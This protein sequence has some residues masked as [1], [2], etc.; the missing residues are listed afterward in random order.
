MEN[1]QEP[2]KIDIKYVDDVN[3]FREAAISYEQNK[4]YTPLLRELRNINDIGKN[5]YIGV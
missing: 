2:F 5:N 1:I 3:K 4:Y